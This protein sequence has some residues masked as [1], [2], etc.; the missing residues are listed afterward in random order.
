MLALSIVSEPKDALASA[1]SESRDALPQDAWAESTDVLP[2]D[3][4]LRSKALIVWAVW[5]WKT[6]LFQPDCLPSDDC[7]WSPSC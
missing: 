5:A 4:L 3:A 7:Q 1:M 2:P 6:A